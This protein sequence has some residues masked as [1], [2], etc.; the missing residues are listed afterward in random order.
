MSKVSY[1]ITLPVSAQMDLSAGINQR[2]LPMVSQAINGIAQATASRWIDAVQHGKMRPAE[3][4]AYAKSIS[5]RPTGEFSAVVESDYQYASDIET[6]RPP[7]DL[8]DMLRTSKKIRYV[9]KGKNAGKRYLIIPMR[10]NTEG[11]DA[12]APSMPGP[13][14][15]MAKALTFSKI[16]GTQMQHNG[17]T[18]ARARVVKRN[19]YAWGGRLSGEDL[20]A[21]GASPFQQ[22]RYAGMVRFN[23]RTPGGAKS[24]SYLTFRVMGEWSNGW[25]IKA[26]PGQFLARDVAQEMQP[27]AET[28]I[29]EAVR[30]SLG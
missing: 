25:I 13:V 21:A 22:R 19:T 14:Q 8:K 16:T 10:H 28:W 1:Q 11:N 20:A 3:K 9:T 24:A 7:R 15:A 26:Q 30:R 5:V 18:G 6:G 17:G 12:L 27:V 4:D 23:T 29:A 2:L